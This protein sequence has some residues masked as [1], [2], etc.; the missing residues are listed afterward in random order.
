MANKRKIGI[1]SDKNFVGSFTRYVFASEILQCDT[2]G[3][4]NELTKK[5]DRQD[6]MEVFLCEFKMFNYI[7][8]IEQA[9]CDLL[10]VLYTKQVID[11]DRLYHFLVGQLKRYRSIKE[12][13]IAIALLDKQTSGNR[14]NLCSP[15]ILLYVCGLS[16]G[17]FITIIRD[18]VSDIKSKED[19]VEKLDKFNDDRTDFIHNLLSS[20]NNSF[21]QI[22]K[23]LAEAAK[24]KSL[25]ED[26][27]HR[28]RPPLL[29]V[30]VKIKK[31]QGSFDH[32]HS[33]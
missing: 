16:F 15:H 30:S 31:F 7:L 2:W 33:N 1:H 32:K 21:V 27:L 26:L 11:H 13:K 5:Y 18:F 17:H 6:L 22:R 29:N 23:G 10:D 3:D 8:L 9:L 24:L 4:V 19:L 12:N 25:I 28:E 14:E 20:R